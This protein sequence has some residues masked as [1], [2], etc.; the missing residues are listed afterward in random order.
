MTRKGL[1]LYSALLF[2]KTLSPPYNPTSR[3]PPSH[4]QFFS[5]ALLTRTQ[6]DAVMVMD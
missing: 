4:F 5:Y 6:T 1:I 3:Y 2:K